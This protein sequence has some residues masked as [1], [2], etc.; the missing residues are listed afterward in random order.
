MSV[1]FFKE[2]CRTSDITHERFGICDDEN[3]DIAYISDKSQQNWV[4]MAI[5]EEN[6]LLVFTPLITA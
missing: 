2:N 1:D 4:A 6:C 3:G 5:N